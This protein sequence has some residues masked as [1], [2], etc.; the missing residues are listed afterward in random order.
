MD[1]WKKYEHKF[2]KIRRSSDHELFIWARLLGCA[3]D[4][5]HFLVEIPEDCK[6][7]PRTFGID[8]VSHMGERFF[9]GLV[10]YNHEFLSEK[11]FTTENEHRRFAW[12]VEKSAQKAERG[13][14]E[15]PPT[16]HIMY[17]G[18]PIREDSIVRTEVQPK[19]IYGMCSAK[20][21]FANGF[22]CHTPEGRLPV[23]EAACTC[24]Y[25]AE[26][27]QKLHKAEMKLHYTTE[28]L[29]SYVD[30]FQLEPV[31]Y[32]YK[33]IASNTKRTM[34]EQLKETVADIRDI[35]KDKFLTDDE[36]LL[37]KY[38]LKD[39]V[40]NWTSRAETAVNILVMEDMKERLIATCKE[41][42][43]LASAKKK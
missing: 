41:Q 36:K 17:R 32:Y 23:F 3:N 30:H 35:V 21:H 37:R 26:M 25:E 16:P 4:Y 28:D 31:C 9:D 7:F 22:I 18:R 8:E 11:H 40:G 24:M 13:L 2:V 42:E 33:P 10:D 19:N 14:I 1:N 12:V 38:G 6:E 27:K 43:A 20:H 34:Y 29:R 39:N 5:Q 15:F